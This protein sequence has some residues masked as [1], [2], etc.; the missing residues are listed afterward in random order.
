[1]TPLCTPT[2][3]TRSVAS[4]HWPLV[5]RVESRWTPRSVAAL[6]RARSART[7][8]ILRPGAIL[9]WLT[10]AVPVLQAE[11][12]TNVA[13]HALRATP[14]AISGKSITF[15]QD[16]TGQTVDYSLSVFPPLEQER[17][18]V[19]LK[20][21]TVPEG[22]QSAHAFAT[23]VL[24]RSRLL[25]ADGQTSEEDYQKT[26]AT[27]MAAFRAQ[28]APLLEQQKLSKERLELI[29]TAMASAKE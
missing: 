12:W 25:Y 8:R 6:I 1:M 16:A 3:G 29:L 27:T 26:V 18:R 19:A 20:D 13:G 17:L 4:G 7:T 11:S 10:L 2:G 5:H 21:T 24:K 9:V 28:A 15:K 14:V 22:L 23:R